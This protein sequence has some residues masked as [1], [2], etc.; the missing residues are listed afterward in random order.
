MR[1]LQFSSFFLRNT[2][3][4][5]REE[6]LQGRSCDLVRVGLCSFVS[7][8]LKLEPESHHCLGWVFWC[9]KCLIQQ[10][11]SDLQV[12]EARQVARG[13]QSFFCLS[14]PMYVRETGK[15][16]KCENVAEGLFLSEPSGQRPSG[17]R[18]RERGASGKT[19]RERE[20]G[21]E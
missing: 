15:N 4:E 9:M 5:A 21:R 2:S 6:R 20:S 11:C 3:S 8:Y 10:S 19:D 14:I 16:M 1:P 12:F 13:R 18:K 17:K 7:Y